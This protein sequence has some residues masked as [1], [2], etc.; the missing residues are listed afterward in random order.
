M[1]DRHVL[2][3][4]FRLFRLRRSLATAVVLA[5]AILCSVSCS[6][7]PAK[8][9]CGVCSNHFALS[10]NG[11]GQPLVDGG[12]GPNPVGRV[13]LEE[14]IDRIRTI[15][16]NDPKRKRIVLFVHGGLVSLGTSAKKSEQIA[17]C[18]SKV[19][20]EIYPV[21]INWDTAL[22]TSYGRHIF[23][24]DAGVA[25]EVKTPLMVASR[26]FMAPLN[27]TADAG[28]GVS[29]LPANAVR[30]MAR[31]GGRNRETAL[32]SPYA[33]PEQYAFARKLHE[34]LGVFVYDYAKRELDRESDLGS[35][36]YRRGFARAYG[37]GRP[38]FHLNIGLG[39]TAV[40]AVSERDVTTLAWSPA[41]SSTLMLAEGVGR[42]AWDN[43]VLRARLL[44]HGHGEFF[45]SPS[46]GT[47]WAEPRAEDFPNRGPGLVLLEK[48]NEIAKDTGCR[49]ELYGHSMGAIVLNGLID[50]MELQGKDLVTE[51]IVYMAAACRI[52]DFRRT[53]G[54]YISRTRTPFYNLCLHPM[55][56]VRESFFDDLG[57]PLIAGSLLTWIDAM[58]ERP[59]SFPD[60]TLGSYS[61][62][63]LAESLLPKGDHVT[64]KAFG[65]DFKATGEGGFLRRD[66]ESDLGPQKHGQFTD[67]QFWQ[68]PFLHPETFEGYSD[69]RL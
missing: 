35:G 25:Y 21:F 64:L 30:A 38:G 18:M 28:M 56:E 43:M 67:Y 69:W 13:E 5:A 39:P 65:A 23:S 19:S 32:L 59:P 3:D 10:I 47:P 34:D 49:L 58:F 16:E 57:S 48:L 61:N 2:A 46:N 14:E 63:V 45:E 42:G 52:S 9:R 8:I 51:R 53:A 4:S 66:W 40:P 11:K 20:E 44:V 36:C 41:K 6:S 60:R 22:H 7:T 50:E 29:R 26:A 68:G 33:Y 1:T 54:R 27:F 62:A 55:Q 12:D 31:L 17:E 15:I 37:T 24:D